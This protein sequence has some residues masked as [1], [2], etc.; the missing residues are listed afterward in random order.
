MPQCPTRNSSFTFDE[1]NMCRQDA[2]FRYE[3]C[4]V[5][6]RSYHNIDNASPGELAVIASSCSFSVPDIFSG[7][8]D[9]KI[10]SA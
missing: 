3:V 2:R 9:N 7:C 5:G 6:A 8:R 4:I 10:I 1:Y